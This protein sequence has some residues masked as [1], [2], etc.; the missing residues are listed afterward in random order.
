MLYSSV[1]FSSDPGPVVEGVTEIAVGGVATNAGFDFT[2]TKGV[3]AV[4]IHANTADITAAF[5]VF[6]NEYEAPATDT[7]PSII[8]TAESGNGS[9]GTYTFVHG[10]RTAM[11][12]NYT[13]TVG[14]TYLPSTAL[15]EGSATTI[16]LASVPATT[17]TGGLG[18]N[19]TVTINVTGINLAALQEGA[20]S[21]TLTITATSVSP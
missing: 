14:G 17:C 3:G 1:C 10:T 20:Y 12:A 9:V 13:V 5:C 7:E 21:D 6:S 18:D 19:E 16:K 15:T 2:A 8:L 4:D 11:T